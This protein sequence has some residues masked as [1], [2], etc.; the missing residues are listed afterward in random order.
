VRGRT[1]IAREIFQKIRDLIAVWPNEEYLASVDIPDFLVPDSSDLSALPGSDERDGSEERES[2]MLSS[3]DLPEDAVSR[4]ILFTRSLWESRTLQENPT[5]QSSKERRSKSRKLVDDSSAGSNGVVDA[6]QYDVLAPAIA[7]LEDLNLRYN[8]LFE[9]ANGPLV[10]AMKAGEM[11]LLDE[12][13]LAEDAVL[14]RLNSVLEPSRTLVLAEKGANEDDDGE[15]RLIKAHPSFQMFATMNPGGD[16][17]KRELS[18]ALRSRFTEIWVPPV[19]DHFDIDLVLECS[20]TCDELATTRKVVKEKMMEYVAWFNGPVCCDP[21]RPCSELTLSLR[22]ILTWARF[23]VAA[24][25]VNK[26]LDVWGAYRHGASLMHLDGL[27][28]GTGLGVDDALSTKTRA[29]LFLVERMPSSEYLSNTLLGPTQFR[30]RDEK[31]GTD[32]FWISTGPH[33]GPEVMFNLEAPTTSIN[34]LRVLRA[35]QLSKPV[36]LEGSPGVGKTSLIGALAAASGHRL[37]RI[38]LSEQT[39]IADLIGSDLPVPE[40][41][42]QGVSRAAFRWCDGVLLSAIK[43]G[44]WVLLDELNLASQ[45]VLEGLNSCLDHRASVYIPE[46]GRT[47][48]CPPTFRVFAAQ[49]PLGQGGGR[50]GLPKSFLN[51]FTKVYVDALTSN[52]L[53]SIVG[54]RFPSVSKSLVDKLVDFNSQIHEDVVE[55]CA[56]GQAGSPWEFNLRDIFRWCELFVPSQDSNDSSVSPQF[57]RDLYFQ[58]FRTSSDRAELRAR[59]SAT[60]DADINSAAVPELTVTDTTVQIGDVVLPRRRTESCGRQDVLGMEPTLSLSLLEP[61]VAVARCVAM[62]WPCLLVGP[63]GSG[64]ESLVSGLAEL[65]NTRLIRVALSPSSDVSEIIGCF[66]QVGSLDQ[67]HDLLLSLKSIATDCLHSGSARKSERIGELALALNDTFDSVDTNMNDRVER[68]FELASLL[69]SATIELPTFKECHEREIAS[70]LDILQKMR[71]SIGRSQDRVD[72]HFEWKDGVLVQAM[73]DGHWLLLQNANLCP[74]SVLDR[75]NSVMEPDGSLLL[76]ECGTTDDDDSAG[77]THRQVRCHPNFR[78]FLS[79]D[80][81]QGEV[82]RAMRNRCVEI[83]L[84]GV[85]HHEG[86]RSYIDGLDTFWRAGLRSSLL[87]TTLLRVH[88]NVHGHGE[89]NHAE[90]LKPGGV[91]SLGCVLSSLQSRGVLPELSLSACFRIMFSLDPE[92]SNHLSKEISTLLA[93]EKSVALAPRPSIRSDLAPFAEY[94]RID[95]EARLLRLFAG[96]GQTLPSSEVLLQEELRKLDE[97]VSKPDL[98]EKYEWLDPLRPDDSQGLVKMRDHFLSLFLGKVNQYGYLDRVEFLQTLDDSGGKSLRFMAKSIRKVLEN[99]VSHTSREGSAVDFRSSKGIQSIGIRRLPQLLQERVWFER[100]QK[101]GE[102]AAITEGSSVLAVSFFVSDGRIDRSSILCPITPTLYPLFRTFDQWVEILMVLLSQIQA[103]IDSN[104]SEVLVTLLSRRDELWDLLLSSEF[105]VEETEFLGFDE[106]EF[107]VQ[108][109]WF[110]KA[111]RAMEGIQS[112]PSSTLLEENKRRLNVLIEA[113]DHVIY[114]SAS[115]GI[116]FGASVLKRSTRPLVPRKIEHWKVLLAL[117]DIVKFSSLDLHSLQESGSGTELTLPVELRDLVRLR[118]PVLFVDNKIKREVLA[119][120]CTLHLTYTDEGSGKEIFP[121]GK[122]HDVFRRQIAKAELEFSTELDS[123]K[124]DTQTEK[125]ENLMSVEELEVTMSAGHEVEIAYSRMTEMLL[126]EFGNLQLSPSVEFWCEYEETRLIREIYRIL[127]EKRNINSDRPMF[128]ALRDS[129]QKFVRIVISRTSWTV[130]DLR[131]YQSILWMIEGA[132][133]GEP[134]HERFVRCLLPQMSYNASRRTWSGAIYRFWSISRRLELPAL[135]DATASTDNDENGKVYQNSK[136]PE[137]MWRAMQHTPSSTVFSL[138]AERFLSEPETQCLRSITTIENFRARAMQ[139]RDLVDVLSTLEPEMHAE[140]PFEISYL[141]IDI[142]EAL[143]GSFPDDGLVEELISNA[144]RSDLPAPAD[145]ARLRSL[146]E[147]C[148]NQVLLEFLEPVVLPLFSCLR[149]LWT[150]ANAFSDSS[151]DYALSRVY[152]GLLRFHLLIPDSPLDPGR[153]PIAKVAL[154]ERRLSDL[155]LEVSAN[156]IDCGVSTGDFAP[157]SETIHL[158]LD[159][160]RS[161]WEKKQKQGKKVIERPETAS[162]FVHLFRELKD[163]ARRFVGVTS[164][165]SLTNVLN[166]TA[167]S[168]DSES[169]EHRE[170]N[171]QMTTE[172]FCNR[173][174]SMFA[175]YEDVTLPLVGA[176]ACMKVGLRALLV[177][178][179]AQMGEE[180]KEA[181]VM[182]ACLSFPFVESFTGSDAME[183]TLN[184][185]DRSTRDGST[186]HYD[187]VFAFLSRLAL[188]RLT[189]GANRDILSSWLAALDRLIDGSEVL[190]DRERPFESTEDKEEKEFREQFPDHRKDFQALLRRDDDDDSVESVPVESPEEV[191]DNVLSHGAHKLNDERRELLCSLHRDIFVSSGRPVRD[192]DRVRAFRMSYA[193]GYRAYGSFT[194][195]SDVFMRRVSSAHVMALSLETPSEKT[196]VVSMSTKL[197]VA[198]SQPDFHKDPNPFEVMKAAGPLEHL[199]ARIAQLLTAFPGNDI[200]IAV[201]RVADRVRKFDIFTVSVGKAMTGLEVILK[202]AQDW[203]QHAS[204]RVKLGQPL[205]DISRTVACWRKLELQNWPTLLRTREENFSKRGVKHWDSLYRLLRRASVAPS[206]GNRPTSPEVAKVSLRHL[207]PRWVWKGIKIQAERLLTPLAE[208]SEELSEFVKLLDTF[209]LTSPLGEFKVRLEV[210]EAFASQLH[211]ECSLDGS[212]TGRLHLARAL[213]SLHRY[214]DQFSEFLA[215]KLAG[216]RGPFET[217]LK[218]E[219]KLGK[220]DE[221]SYYALAESSERSHRKLMRI[222]KEYDEVL[223]LSISGILERELCVGVRP[224]AQSHDEPSTV[225]PNFS[226]LFPLGK[227]SETNPTAVAPK[228]G[229]LLEKREWTD[230]VAI[231]FAADNYATR[232]GHFARKMSSLVPTGMEDQQ[233]WARLGSSEASELCE[234]VFQR[235]E[236]LRSEKTTR[237]MKERALVD[238]FRELKE[239]GYT[240][241]KWSIP[242]ELHRMAEIFQVPDPT[243]IGTTTR[244]LDSSTLNSSEKYY[245]RALAEL[246]RLRSEVAMLGSKYLTQRQMD[247]MVGFGGHGLLMLTQQRSAVS[248]LLSERES[249]L[250]LIGDSSFSDSILP[251]SQSYL[252]QRVFL[253]ERDFTSALESLSQLSL[254][255]KSSQHLLDTEVKAEWAREV[256]SQIASVL[257]TNA[258]CTPTYPFFVTRQRIQT[259][260]DKLSALEAAVTMLRNRQESCSNLGCLPIVAFETCDAKIV[261]A[262]ASASHCTEPPPSVPETDGIHEDKLNSF[263]ECCSLSVQSSLLAVQAIKKDSEDDKTNVTD[264]SS[265]IW[266]SHRAAATEWASIDLKRMNS[267]FRDV[268]AQLISIHENDSINVEARSCCT[269]VASDLSVL[270][271]NAINVVD[272]RLQ[273]YISFYRNTAKLHYIL[274]RIFRVL[275]SKGFCTDETSEGDGE[276]EGDASGMTFEDGTGMG[277]GEGKTDVTDQIE[278]EEQLL[279]LKNDKEDEEKADQGQSKEL[280]E[281]EAEKGMEMEGDFDGEM[282]DMPDKKPDD[283]ADGEDDEEEELD[284]EMGDDGGPNEEVIDEKMWDESDDE[285]DAGKGEEKLEKDSAVEGTAADDE[286]MTKE[287]GDDEQDG[288]KNDPQQGDQNQED[289]KEEEGEND[290]KMD[291]MINDDAEDNYEDSHGLDVRGDETKDDEEEKPLELDENLEIDETAENEDDEQASADDGDE[292][293]AGADDVVP[294]PEDPAAENE[295]QDARPED[296]GEDPNEEEPGAGETRMDPDTI[297]EE[298]PEGDQLEDTD[299][300]PLKEPDASEAQKGLGV[301]AQDGK[302][303]V[304]DAAEEDEEEGGGGAEEENE[305][306]NGAEPSD[307]EPSGQGGNSSGNKDGQN[308]AEG[309]EAGTQRHNSQEIPNPLTS[310]G[311]AKKFWHRKL[312]IVNSQSEMD[313]E[314]DKT[315]QQNEE[316]NGQKD[317]D[318]EFAGD[319]EQ[320]TTQTLAGVDENDATQLQQEQPEE[321]ATEI[322]KDTT[323]EETKTPETSEQPTKRRVSKP[324]ANTPSDDSDDNSINDMD[325][326]SE[327][328]DADEL[329]DDED[330]PEEDNSDADAEDHIPTGN[331]VVSDLSQLQVNDESMDLQ[332]MPHRIIEEEQTAGVSSAEAAQARARWSQILGETHSLSRRLCEKLRLVMEP[333]VASK[334]RGDYRTGKRINMKRVIGY[335]ASGY[336]KDKIWLRRT[337]PAKRNYRIL[338]AVDDSESMLKSGAGEM[339]LKAMATLATGMSQL[340]IGEIGVASFGNEMNLLHPFNQPFTAESGSNVVRNFKF[341]QQRTRTALCVESAL[342]ALDT[343]GDQA[344]MQLMFMISDGRIERDSRTAL[345]RLMREMAEKNI[346]LAMIIVEGGDSKKNSITTMKEVTFENGKPNVKRFI[347]DYPFPYYIILDDMRTLPEVL[348]DA[349]RQWFEMLTRLQASTS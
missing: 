18:P 37:I 176:I 140:G 308:L 4:M 254:L 151:R 200:L 179:A 203:E 22:D 206:Q 143:S 222:L 118:H 8:A 252:R 195:S 312:N 288:G 321:K 171:W 124:I 94:S 108:W 142:L 125:V 289:P 183:A 137:V 58:R 96:F 117:Q 246:N 81:E 341:D 130:T 32:P 159:E 292:E 28:L 338:V 231:R 157:D 287:E 7:E 63:S 91:Q 313:D 56:F 228:R 214:Y 339:A 146:L 170:S 327:G 87:A 211:E 129:L 110:R 15:S 236:A 249:L 145:E 156:R 148:T 178:R 77:P 328:G 205:R 291:E 123:I 347:E 303:A 31:F 315:G 30:V 52:D 340:E 334:L 162:S 326:E 155:R 36:L 49:N 115:G 239:Q 188:D 79:V 298:P 256:L 305:D 275:V 127:V 237:P 3:I 39:D 191:D 286:M 301:R 144:T 154:I 259:V 230:P 158:L 309:S 235:I 55:S 345:R 23:I 238:L 16:F 119:A 68:A 346:L 98:S 204:D 128:N 258:Y 126:R 86:P 71:S 50:K 167:S 290:E 135:L 168:S 84:L 149:R 70:A 1:R 250:E 223:E 317:G 172:A 302:D 133:T 131:P 95:W 75:L 88:E 310:P 202:H 136:T 141:L 102:G 34:V 273:D 234:A 274:L 294:D 89:A 196:P 225:I 244:S 190:G 72:G 174:T 277:E 322:S 307:I 220:W 69:S 80:P 201:G 17:G 61:M 64:K 336:R 138:V 78:I 323:P 147:K 261:V 90:Q 92:K 25:Q 221:Q 41:D 107:I 218:A 57:A 20:L 267:R 163:F 316:N 197:S 335:I 271:S 105:S 319:D 100:T 74:S 262:M 240:S 199:M 296:E 33:L 300:E 161:L 266:D 332:M 112:L 9:W 243:A 192:F 45:S 160:G 139:S 318:F 24:V 10:H 251:T 67:Y 209:V 282:Y 216:L 304:E 101:Y 13:S 253:F 193:A 333:L 106:T 264:M 116:Y 21:T 276:A 330:D 242:K 229:K 134:I 29:E 152:L 6:E 270:L 99:D 66:E 285:D 245:H 226:A 62:N 187:L 265:S 283:G 40:K 181:S 177:Q 281:E 103:E 325:V 111:L 269:G 27:G 43:A 38:N 268:L 113:V 164:V 194:C 93:T 306:G 257:S 35:M 233:S 73:T 278:N 224:D 232:I 48:D 337:K 121:I 227:G 42:S 165:L 248:G 12:M 76:A 83:S 324:T 166:D 120:L 85:F 331:Q 53:R 215:T 349:L 2:K 175:V 153:K 104:L 207:S 150:S 212:N 189:I 47:F 293:G 182:K 217:R 208:T 51:R 59:Y 186:Y 82:S 272:M 314:A 247:M 219:T 299:P 198:D 320:N 213:G 173:L 180:S 19:T 344:S 132:L 343:P 311:D 185:I 329:G 46:L 342:M 260:A 210:I 60:F 263:A 280:D 255:V 348:G 297:G 14:E 169:V 114:D 295:E 241:T 184:S 109:T 279:G 54:T 11:I 5:A 65:C 97:S 26:D 284:R 122:V 44:D